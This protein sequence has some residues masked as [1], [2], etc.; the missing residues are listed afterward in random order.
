MRRLFLLIPALIL[1]ASP[2]MA[3]TFYSEAPSMR[4]GFGGV[5]AMYEGDVYIGSA[6]ITWPAGADPI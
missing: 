3:Q 2:L 6:P 4:L 5:V 1:A